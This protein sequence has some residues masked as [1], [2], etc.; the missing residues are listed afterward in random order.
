M[1]FWS[2][3]H[4]SALVLFVVTAADTKVTTHT[5]TEDPNRLGVS[6]LIIHATGPEA[7]RA[8]TPKA[9]FL[10]INLPFKQL[11]TK[12]M[13]VHKKSVMAIYAEEAH[14]GQGAISALY[15]DGKKYRYQPM[16]M[17]ME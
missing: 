16:G 2:E 14:E 15:W 5:A 4:P 7:W 13:M 10:I 11:A 3:L 17:S 9:K 6:L 8:A 12:K 1:Q